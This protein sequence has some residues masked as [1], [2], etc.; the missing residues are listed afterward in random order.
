MCLQPSAAPPAIR[1]LEPLSH[2]VTCSMVGRARNLRLHTRMPNTSPGLHAHVRHHVFGGVCR[3]AL[4]TLPSSTVVHAHRIIHK[5]PKASGAPAAAATP[6]SG[7]TCKGGTA[8]HG[9][10]TDFR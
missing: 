4:V 3:Y 5:L 9:S 1:T 8:A 10:A 7:P 6:E 2:M